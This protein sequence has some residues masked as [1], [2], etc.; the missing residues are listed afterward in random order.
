MIDTTRTLRK[1]I[2]YKSVII[3][4]TIFL[5]I[6]T[7]AVTLGSYFTFLLQAPVS[8]YT[9]FFNRHLTLTRSGGLGIYVI[10]SREESYSNEKEKKREKNG[11]RT[12]KKGASFNGICFRDRNGVFF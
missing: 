2:K 6:C 1:S 10:D 7:C 12:D 4:K 11:D 5:K 3:S 9:C 8:I